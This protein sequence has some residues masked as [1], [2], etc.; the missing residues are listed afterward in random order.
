MSRGRVLPAE[1]S[2][3]VEDEAGERAAFG[4]D[5]GFDGVQVA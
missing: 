3:P 4:N 1:V 2:G 5:R